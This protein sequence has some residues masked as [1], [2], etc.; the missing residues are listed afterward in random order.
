MCVRRSGGKTNL[1]E[2]LG[3]NSCSRCSRPW[4][5]S[6]D[7]P[8]PHF[9]GRVRERN[10]EIPLGEMC[11]RDVFLRIPGKIPFRNELGFGR[12]CP[13]DLPKLPMLP[14]R[15]CAPRHATQDKHGHAPL[16]LPLGKRRFLASWGAREA[17]LAHHADARKKPNAQATNMRLGS[18]PRT[19]QGL[20]S[21]AG[22][23]DTLVRPTPSSARASPCRGR[24]LRSAWSQADRWRGDLQ[25]TERVCFCSFQW[26]ARPDRAPLMCLSCA[27]RPLAVHMR[28]A[29][30]PM[31]HLLAPTSAEVWPE[32][33][34]IARV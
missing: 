31:V 9:G 14:N 34:G 29:H 3:R 32:L 15:P 17:V 12:R 13:G 5:D 27:V 26:Y 19:P 8:I 6:G 25:L 21:S 18:S 11:R 1:R 24:G 28:A 7:P 30:Q 33:A 22:G 2:K 16:S 4:G 23:T 20:S 10:G